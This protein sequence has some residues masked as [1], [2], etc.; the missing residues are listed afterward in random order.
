MK[1]TVDIDH[2]EV[3][4]S[5]IINYLA[6]SART[7]KQQIESLLSKDSLRQYQIEDLNVSTDIYECLKRV[8]EYYTTEDQ[9]QNELADIFEEE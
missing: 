7:E 9:R 3:L 8:I 5:I 1:F 2:V 4:D 6:E